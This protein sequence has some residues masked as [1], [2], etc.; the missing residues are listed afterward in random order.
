MPSLSHRFEAFSRTITQWTG[1]TA[2]FLLALTTIGVW[3]L[4]GPI[5]QYSETWQLIINTGTTIITFLMVFLIQRAQN[6]DS[7]ALH[8]K[9]NELIAA[10]KTASNRLVNAE[11]LDEEELQIL[12]KYF[13]RLAAEARADADLH[14]THT[15]D[16]AAANQEEK[17]AHRRQRRG[18]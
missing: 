2:A 15:P 12:H 11:D 4:T 5:F 6:K 16:E 1:S 14:H 8:M 17:D 13:A 18:K 3:G 9:L 7:L 10:T